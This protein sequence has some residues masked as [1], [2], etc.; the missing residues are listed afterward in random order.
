MKGVLTIIKKIVCLKAVLLSRGQKNKSPDWIV[1]IFFLKSV[2]FKKKVARSLFL[3][4]RSAYHQDKTTVSKCYADFMQ[5]LSGCNRDKKYKRK[6]MSK[7]GKIYM[8]IYKSFLD[9]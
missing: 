6:W 8:Y 3:S 5:V 1:W 2:H 7:I 9:H 4:K